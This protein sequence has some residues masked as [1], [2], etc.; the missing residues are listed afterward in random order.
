MRGS[1]T[2]RESFELLVREAQAGSRE[3][4]VAL[5]EGCEGRL[6]ALVER[7]TGPKVRSQQE[8]ADIVQEVLLRAF[9]S[10]GSFRWRGEGSFF[11]WLSGIAENVLLDLGD[12]RR[13][14]PLL[15]L[16][17]DV[18]AKGS[19]PGGKLRSE[20]RFDRL[21]AALDRLSPDHRQVILLA[22]IEGLPMEEIGK[23]MDRSP[24]AAAQLLWRALRKLRLV[25]GETE[26]FGLPDRTLGKG[27]ARDG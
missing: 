27:G 8:P 6:R 2:A 3:A 13:R 22:R 10:I 4:F 9:R 26:S 16:E 17:R 23:R 5:L 14:G 11:G 20:E 18:L 24:N 1:M 21:R 15:R 7:R 12:P 25:F 19:S